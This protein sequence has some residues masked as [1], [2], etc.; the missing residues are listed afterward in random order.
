MMQISAAPTPDQHPWQAEAKHA[1]RLCLAGTALG[2]AALSAWAALAPLAS[3]VV[4][5]GT[6]KTAGNRKTVQHAEGGIVAAI[7][8]KDGDQVQAGQVLI[9]LSDQRVAATFDSLRQQWVSETLKAKRL[10]AE[11]QGLPFSTTLLDTKSVRSTN[12][13]RTELVEVLKTISPALDKHITTTQQREQ[14][15][16]TARA[17]QQAEQ[18]HWLAQQRS[19]VQAEMQAHAQLIATT[20]SAQQLAQRE[21]ATNE[22][23]KQEGFVSEVK[24]IE[25]QRSVAD[26][27]AR[28]ET[29]QAQRT[30]AQQKEADLQLRLAAQK[31]DFAKQAADE[32]KDTSQKLSQISQELRPALDAQTRQHIT[33]PVAGEVV[34]LKV[35]TVGSSLAPRESVLDIVPSGALVI[36]V[37]ITPQ[38]IQDVQTLARTS[39]ADAKGSN[40]NTGINSVNNANVMLTAYRTR[41]TPQVA[42][43]ISY[44]GADRL[45]DPTT[46]APY[47]LAHITVSEQA[48]KEA[49]ALAG[50]ALTLSPG[51][52]AEVFMAT[53]E[54]TAFRY[55]LDP[56]L[57]GV[58]RSMRER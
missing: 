8:V 57:D 41:A 22:K 56:I 29:A 11:S 44:V 14:A 42:G 17:H 12:F 31:A 5:D 26:Y 10:E 28:Y 52:Q 16:Y 37:R 49:S 39:S 54:R 21:L 30:Q 46:R 27:R 51:M 48:L 6:V 1:L 2:I 18:A 35:H 24:L 58:R 19:Q 50:Q 3:A 38:D 9:T 20:Q 45:T 53:Q 25:L 47:Y 34:D 23:L 13:I 55:L 43:R 40:S 32:L 36:E 7:H 15:V 4:A 33:A